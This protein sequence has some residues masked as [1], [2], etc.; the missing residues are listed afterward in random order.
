MY[1][2]G[3]KNKLNTSSIF[4]SYEL[5]GKHNDKYIIDH[6]EKVENPR[7][8]KF[9]FLLGYY[10]DENE[11][12]I[13]PILMGGGWTG[14]TERQVYKK[15]SETD[16]KFYGENSWDFF[17]EYSINISQVFVSEDDA[18]TILNMYLR[19]NIIEAKK[20]LY[21]LEVQMNDLKKKNFCYS[22]N[23]NNEIIVSE[24]GLTNKELDTVIRKLYEDKLNKDWIKFTE[25]VDELTNRYNILNE[26]KNISDNK[27]KEIINDNAA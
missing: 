22:F 24:S 17:N 11:E 25:N 23:S 8:S 13:V 12:V 3:P 9:P 7:E 4:S 18:K 14:Y 21:L 2:F 26:I 16:K 5:Y 1:K 27:K 19:K 20:R 15:C 6:C 10:I